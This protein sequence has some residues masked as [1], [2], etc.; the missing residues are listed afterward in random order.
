MAVIR[1]PEAIWQ[2]IHEHLF[3]IPGEHFAFMLARHS[4]SQGKPVF[5]V[6]DAI[7]VPDSDAML[8]DDGWS[9]RPEGFLPAINAAVRSGSALIEAHN[10]GGRRP[11]FSLTDRQGLREFPPYVLSSLPGRP[12]GA[13]VW[14][15]ST[16]YGEFFSE[17]GTGTISSITV[18]GHRLR[19]LVSRH[20]DDDALSDTFDRQ[21]PWFTESGQRSLSR[22]RVAVVGAGGTGSQVVQN[23]AYLGLCDFVVVDHDEADD[24]SMNRLVTAVAADI[25]TPKAMLA[26]RLVKSVTPQARVMV[27]TSRVQSAVALD[28]LKGVDVIFGCV[29][30]DGARLLLNELA[31]A[32]AIPYLDLA[33]GIEAADG[34]VSEA[35]GRL[36]VVTPDGPCL[37]CM[38]EIDMD[39]ARFFLS[40]P[41]DQA[42]Q[43]E[44]GYVRGMGVRAPAVVSLNAAVAA[45]ATS[46][47]GI[48]VSGVRPVA[49]LVHLDLLGTG[50]TK[51][52]WLTP[53]AA[54]KNDG[55]VHCTVAG[56]ADA[57]GLERYSKTLLVS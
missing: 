37:A 23:L 40:S 42:F 15:D 53:T 20:D 41:E 4:A 32:Y 30:N 8:E 27:V 51:G 47:L 3:S 6:E 57:I 52:Q 39:E 50:R 56:H 49:P 21:L 54:T 12:Y 45:A 44:R 5:I 18:T 38:G 16:I 43:L 19:Q 7:C 10:H 55:C 46:E 33:V 24:T 36:A 22:L 2:K 13:T 11:R 28:I 17:A 48:F 34:K 14:G 9:L 26:R 1:L 31:K 35:G 29:D 25:G